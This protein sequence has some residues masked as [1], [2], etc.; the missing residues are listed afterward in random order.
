MC[1]TEQNLCIKLNHAFGSNNIVALVPGSRKVNGVSVAGGTFG[2]IFAFK[3]RQT[4]AMLFVVGFCFVFNLKQY[5]NCH[6]M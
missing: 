2:T 5:L 4:Q 1:R 3:S 6:Q